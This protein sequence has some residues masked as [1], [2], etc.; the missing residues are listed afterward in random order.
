MDSN[1]NPV[2]WLKGGTYRIFAEGKN[3]Q[4]DDDDVAILRKEKIYQR[5][6]S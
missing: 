4:L 5:R 1:R 2:H 6:V 3:L